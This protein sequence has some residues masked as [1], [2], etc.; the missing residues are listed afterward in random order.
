MRERHIFNLFGSKKEKAPSEGPGINGE[1]Y[2][3]LTERLGAKTSQERIKNDPD[4]YGTIA[5]AVSETAVSA[6]YETHRNDP[7]FPADSKIP[8]WEQ[9]KA[10]AHDA[11]SEFENEVLVYNGTENV[12]ADKD[13]KEL[14]ASMKKASGA[15]KFINAE[16]LLPLI[17][18]I[19]PNATA[20]SVASA[21]KKADFYT[22]RTMVAKMIG[23]D[24]AATRRDPEATKAFLKKKLAEEEARTGK[25]DYFMNLVDSISESGET[26]DDK[27]LLALEMGLRLANTTWA[28]AQPLRGIYE[29][30]TKGKT[31]RGD[32]TEYPT[33]AAFDDMVKRMYDAG[34][35]DR[36][37]FEV[38]KD[39]EQLGEFLAQTE[40]Q[41]S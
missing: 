38:M 18:A 36:A 16:H 11:A 17:N 41:S 32:V 3:A 10:A 40:K 23:T 14:E 20:E 29:M 39:L 13:P 8:V 1:K 37:A 33:Y 22:I 28:A 12:L 35:L 21:I 25:P 31:S 9:F 19:N 6:L 27:E 26:P 7:R 34:G 2:A 4:V 5:D 15:A 24:E 30:Q